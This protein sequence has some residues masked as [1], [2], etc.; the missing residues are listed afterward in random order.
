MAP[1]RLDDRDIEE[2]VCHLPPEAESEDSELSE[3]GDEEV[4]VASAAARGHT[5]KNAGL[6]V[7]QNG[8]ILTQKITDMGSDPIWVIKVELVGLKCV[9]QWLGQKFD[10]KLDQLRGQYEYMAGLFTTIPG[11]PHNPNLGQYINIYWVV[12]H[13]LWIPT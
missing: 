3:S 7:T 8:L 12:Y 6:K 4:Q 10:P 1:H 13:Y 5:Q 2:L 9:T 11:F